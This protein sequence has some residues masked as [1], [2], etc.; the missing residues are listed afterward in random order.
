MIGETKK[1]LVVQSKEKARNYK[2]E[3]EYKNTIMLD[4]DVL[5]CES[6]KSRN[7]VFSNG[8]GSVPPMEGQVYI[9]NPY[10]PQEYI[11][12]SNHL[13]K[14]FEKERL[15][16]YFDLA[17][18]LGATKISYSGG[19]SSKE[20]GTKKYNANSVQTFMEQIGLEEQNYSFTQKFK[21]FEGYDQ[22]AYE[23]AKLFVRENHLD[24]DADFT[25]LLSGRD[26]SKGLLESLEVKYSFRKTASTIFTL[27][28]NFDGL[29]KAIGMTSPLA[30]L[31]PTGINVEMAKEILVS[32][33]VHLTIDFD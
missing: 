3:N 30:V 8:Q 10:K 16:K 20:R 12:Q 26:P 22:S 17:H 31:L 33:E 13:L 9:Q 6:V 21:R 7:L 19:E 27:A 15:N 18:R 23:E 2:W 1:M 28:A 32:K 11:E 29:A 25:L 14:D 4:I 24:R 5:S